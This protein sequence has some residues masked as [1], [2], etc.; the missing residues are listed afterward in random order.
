MHLREGQW[1]FEVD[2]DDGAVSVA[3]LLLCDAEVNVVKT[4]ALCRYGFGVG[5]LCAC[6][7]RVFCIGKRD[8]KVTVA[9]F[10][11]VKRGVAVVH[12][13]PRNRDDSQVFFEKFPVCEILAP[14]DVDIKVKFTFV[15]VEIDGV[16]GCGASQ[17]KGIKAFLLALALVDQLKR[18]LRNRALL[19]MGTEY[20]RN[21][22]AVSGLLIAFFADAKIS[23]ARRAFGIDLRRQSDL[24]K[25][26][27]GVFDCPPVLGAGPF[28]T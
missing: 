20:I 15:K 6:E 28:V 3:V 4:V 24:M 5:Q 18:N 13:G 7:E 17:G 10:R 27:P 25:P 2:V 8:A 26:R 23:K 16:D 19:F 14:F 12:I 1:L 9:R 22:S 21:I 11:E